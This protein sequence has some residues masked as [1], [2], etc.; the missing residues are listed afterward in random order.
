MHPDAQS[1]ISAHYWRPVR[2]P[3]LVRAA[4]WVWML[5]DGHECG[6]LSLFSDTRGSF[7]VNSAAHGVLVVSEAG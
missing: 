5:A 6:A 4:R 1:A 7:D 3:P 2:W